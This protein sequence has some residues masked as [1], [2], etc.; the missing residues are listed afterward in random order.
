[1]N[2]SVGDTIN[3]DKPQHALNVEFDI[4]APIEIIAYNLPGYKYMSMEWSL[5]LMPNRGNLYKSVGR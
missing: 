1:M 5:N 4:Y 2:M 3:R